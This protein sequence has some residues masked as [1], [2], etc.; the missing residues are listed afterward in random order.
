MTFHGNLKE[1][2][3]VRIV[4]DSSDPEERAPSIKWLMERQME[5]W[6]SEG[7]TRRTVMKELGITGRKG[8]ALMRHP[9]YKRLQEFLSKSES[10]KMQRMLHKVDT[11]FVWDRYKLE[12]LSKLGRK[13]SRRFQFYLRY[14]MA[15]DD[16]VFRNQNQY[17]LRLVYSAA[18]KE[19]MVVKVAIWALAKRPNEYVKGILDLKTASRRELQE[20]RY[21]QEFLSLQRKKLRQ[22]G[23]SLN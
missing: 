6:V 12:Q 20:N 23:M 2:R 5:R 3:R 13:K 7:A 16:M 1:A 19:E 8:K 9:N 4:S 22:Q 21:Y 11:T 18:S 10:S 14:S 15:Y 17:L